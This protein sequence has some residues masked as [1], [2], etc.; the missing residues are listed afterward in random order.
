MALAITQNKFQ[1]PL[2]QISHLVCGWKV[3]AVHNYFLG[4][5]YKI[6]QQKAYCIH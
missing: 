3:T 5:G 6:R 1:N 4:K 2:P